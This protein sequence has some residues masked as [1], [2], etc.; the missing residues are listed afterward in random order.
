MNE[1]LS[2]IHKLTKQLDHK[3][4]NI[5]EV[6]EEERPQLLMTFQIFYTSTHFTRSPFGL[7]SIS[8]IN[9]LNLSNYIP[10]IKL[11]TNFKIYLEFE[12]NEIKNQTEEFEVVKT[13]GEVKNLSNILNKEQIVLFDHEQDPQD[14]IR[15]GKSY[16]VKAASM[17]TR[18]YVRF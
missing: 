4:Q 14:V 2:K 9:L 10:D 1:I 7:I 12:L 5:R 17:L 3:E 16:Y 13:S 8:D 18:S 11:P 15:Q 6:S